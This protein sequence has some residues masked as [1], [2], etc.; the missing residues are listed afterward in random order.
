MKTKTPLKMH[1]VRLV[2]DE[3][4]TVNTLHMHAADLRWTKDAYINV[5]AL[6]DDY[7]ANCETSF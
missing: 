5:Y 3:I 6:N 2:N 7:N 1:V 4:Q